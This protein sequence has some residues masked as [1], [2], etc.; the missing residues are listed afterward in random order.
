[1]PKQLSGFLH[2]LCIFLLATLQATSVWAEDRKSTA[3]AFA[4]GDIWVAAT[5]MDVPDDDHAG[6]GR[7]IQYD[8]DR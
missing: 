7:L 3:Q 2:L 4:P 8:A 6:T 1:M 5:V